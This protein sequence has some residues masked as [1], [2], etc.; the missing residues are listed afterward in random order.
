MG[1]NG[2]MISTNDVV[3]ESGVHEETFAQ[4]KA[5]GP[6]NALVGWWL[7][8]A[9]KPAAAAPATPATT[10]TT[11]PQGGSGTAVQSTAPG[12]SPPGWV[13]FGRPEH[14]ARDLP[15]GLRHCHR[16]EQLGAER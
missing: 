13:R 6:Y 11:A 3:G 5:K 10:D 15:P 14:S 16:A 9:T 4:L 8:D 2:E 12:T 7:P 1:A